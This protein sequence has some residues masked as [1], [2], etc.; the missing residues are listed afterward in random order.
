M[1]TENEQNFI[2]CTHDRFICKL[3]SRLGVR[4]IIVLTEGWGGRGLENFQI[5][6]L[7]IYAAP[8][9]NNFNFCVLCLP[10]KTIFLLAYNLF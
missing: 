8:A 2:T 7:Y 6:F 1:K 4:D 3:G 9:A 5:I 10:A